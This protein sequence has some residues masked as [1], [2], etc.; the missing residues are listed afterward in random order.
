VASLLA[1]DV[2]GCWFVNPFVQVPERSDF[3]YGLLTRRWERAFQH[4]RDQLAN[5]LRFE[6][7]R[8]VDAHVAK[9][10]WLVFHFNKSMESFPGHVPL[11]DIDAPR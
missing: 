9:I 8:A 7:G 3:G 1:R 4:I 5:R 6:P 2:D 10:R 11:I